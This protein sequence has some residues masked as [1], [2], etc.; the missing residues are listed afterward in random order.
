MY[1]SYLGRLICGLLVLRVDLQLEERKVWTPSCESRVVSQLRLNMLGP[2][3]ESA[4]DLQ[5][6]K[7]RMILVTSRE[8]IC[9]WDK[10]NQTQIAS[11]GWTCNWNYRRAPIVSRGWTCNSEQKFLDPSC[12]W[13]MDL[14]LGQ[15]NVRPQLWVG[16]GLAT[17][18]KKV[19]RQLRVKGGLATRTK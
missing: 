10:K 15:K 19:G 18:T 14:Q 2:S 6:R 11:R 1:P 9:N 12:M 8:W 5:L 7:N 4:L 16:A 13:R 3:C 17:V